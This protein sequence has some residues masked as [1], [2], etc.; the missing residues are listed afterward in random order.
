[1]A[2][3]NLIGNKMKFEVTTDPVSSYSSLSVTSASF[4]VKRRSF[5]LVVIVQPSNAK[6]SVRFGVQPVVEVRDVGTG[7]RAHP[8][9]EHWT[10]TVSLVSGA[11][12]A[13]LSGT[14]NVTIENERAVFTDLSVSIYGTNTVLEFVSSSGHKVCS[15]VQQN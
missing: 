2:F 4:D 5:F 11:P 7:I 12:N 8:L 9:K 6:Q 13:T 15:T 3:F 14:T 1:M 10:L